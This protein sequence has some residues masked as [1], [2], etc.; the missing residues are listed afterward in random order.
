MNFRSCIS[1]NGRDSKVNIDD[2]GRICVTLDVR[3][4][5]ERTIKGLLKYG[6]NGCSLSELTDA[7]NGGAKN[8]Y[9]CED[10]NYALKKLRTEGIVCVKKNN[11]WVASK[12]AIQL[13]DACEKNNV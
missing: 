3:K 9:L 12:R 13:W 10:I 11:N 2:E 5:C 6:T 4:R 1:F 7:L 8:L